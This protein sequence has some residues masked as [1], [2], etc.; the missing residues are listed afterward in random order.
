MPA[1]RVPS[2]ED[3]RAQFRAGIKKLRLTPPRVK[4]VFKDISW[5]STRDEEFTAAFEGA[6]P[7]NERAGWYEV[8][9]LRASG[10]AKRGW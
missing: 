6:V 10:R 1:T 3:V 5:E 2:D 7:E 9:G 8:L 4:L